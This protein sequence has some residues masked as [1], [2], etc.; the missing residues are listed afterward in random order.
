M[1]NDV[2]KES[3]TG[4]LKC[5]FRAAVSSWRRIEFKCSVSACRFRESGPDIHF[6]VHEIL[7]HLTEQADSKTI[8]GRFVDE[9]SFLNVYL[10]VLDHNNR[11]LSE[12]TRGTLLAGAGLDCVVM[13]NRSRP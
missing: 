2:A 3:S 6:S 8:L 9:N 11:L 4:R 13:F 12:R 7:H 10:A 1:N 5:P